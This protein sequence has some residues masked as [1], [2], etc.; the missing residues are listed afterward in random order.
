[1]KNS[2]IA[3][4]WTLAALLMYVTATFQIVSEHF[5][6]GAVFFGAAV[7]FTSVAAKYRKKDGEEK[8]Q[9]KEE[10]GPDEE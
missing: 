2:T 8:Q 6:L 5:I 9:N 10:S 3:K 1:M 4:C 7:C